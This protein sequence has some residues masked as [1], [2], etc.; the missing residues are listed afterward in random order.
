[1]IRNFT[2]ILKNLI[3]KNE[4]VSKIGKTG[5]LGIN[6]NKIQNNNLEEWDTV[7]KE[8]TWLYKLDYKDIYK[9]LVEYIIIS[10]RSQNKRSIKEEASN[11]KINV[12]N[13][14][15]EINC[16]NLN[17]LLSG[18]NNIW[19]SRDC[20]E[21]HYEIL[22]TMILFNLVSRIKMEHRDT[23]G[24]GSSVG[25]SYSRIHSGNDKKK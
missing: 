16:G 2:N 11:E 13:T 5:S 3:E 7:R 1:M 6:M 18:R 9:A 21:E 24:G 8:S 10:R 12:Q 23:G 25:N 14:N 17:A 22:S 15:I 4:S 19:S 20:F